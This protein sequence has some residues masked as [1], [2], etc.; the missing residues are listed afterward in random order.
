[1]DLGLAGKVVLLTGGSGGIGGPTA[2]LFASEGARVALTF[3]RNGEA[4]RQLARDIEE[5]GPGSALAVPYDLTDPATMAAA[6]DTVVST[7]GGLDV[8]VVNASP[9]DGPKPDPVAF[10]DV[11]VDSWRGQL[12][13]EVEGAFHTVQLALRVMRPR[14]WGRVVFVSASVA[15]RGYPGEEAYIASKTALHGLSRTLATEMGADGILSNVVAPGPTVTD[16]L[17]RDKLPPELGRSIAGMDPQARKEAL[18]REMPHLRFST[19]VDVASVVVF[20]GS[21]ANGNVSGSVL[22]VAGGR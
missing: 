7:W 1:M 12:R 18:N 14:G 22:E 2:R 4:A 3:R 21:A 10:E 8:L 11:P 17:L 20:L 6:V 9:A 5:A 16:K 15:G 19:P 13:A